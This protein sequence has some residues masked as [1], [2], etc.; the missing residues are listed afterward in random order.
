MVVD[1]SHIGLGAILTQV[2][3]DEIKV[4]GYASRRLTDTES[5]YSQTEREALSVAW[6]AE[7]FQIDLQRAP[8]TIITDHKALGIIMNKPLYKPTA[9]LERICLRLLP[10]EKTVI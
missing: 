1:A 3:G 6:A 9:R 4:V 2:K 7:P 5:R 10:F 8:F